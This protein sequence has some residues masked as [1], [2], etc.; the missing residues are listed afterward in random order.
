MVRHIPIE[1][2]YPD[3]LDDLGNKPPK[4]LRTSICEFLILMLVMGGAGKIKKSILELPMLIHPTWRVNESLEKGTKGIR[5]FKDWTLNIIDSINDEIENE[6]YSDDFNQS[7]DKLKLE[8]EKDPEVNFPDKYEITEFIEDEIIDDLHDSVREV[9]GNQAELKDG[10]PWLST[11][12]SC[13]CRRSIIGQG[14][15]VEDLILT[16]MPRDAKGK[17]QADTIEQGVDFMDIEKTI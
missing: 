15:T 1:G 14:F 13:S 7:Y 6:D 9:T 12:Y 16:Y 10:F 11:K 8:F 17:N 4:S 2:A 5:T 3:T